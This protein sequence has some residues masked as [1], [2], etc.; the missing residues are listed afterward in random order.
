M[1]TTTRIWLSVIT[2]S[3]VS[4]VIAVTC[5]LRIESGADKKVIGDWGNIGDTITFSF[6]TNGEFAIRQWGAQFSGGFILT[7]GKFEFWDDKT[8]L[9]KEE[10]KEPLAFAISFPTS[11]RLNLQSTNSNESVRLKR[12]NYDLSEREDGVKGLWVE[13]IGEM[14]IYYCFGINSN[15]SGMGIDT[16]IVAAIGLR[17]PTEKG[18]AGTY[19]LIGGT[20]LEMIPTGRTNGFIYEFSF[21]T[22]GR[23]KLIDTIQ[24]LGAQGSP[25]ELS[26]IINQ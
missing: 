26:R 23:L 24:K 5:Y 8:L 2:L 10:S 16:D 19:R 21:P 3:V 14:K 22:P 11:G 6:S 7:T 17:K 20:S 4:S 9:L 12:I 1:S 18:F 13:K 25:M 15:E